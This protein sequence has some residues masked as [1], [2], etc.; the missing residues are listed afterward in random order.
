MDHWHW[1]GR[2]HRS[3]HPGVNIGQSWARGS[4][5]NQSGVRNI[6]ETKPVRLHTDGFSITK[7]LLRRSRGNCTQGMQI[8]TCAVIMECS[9]VPGIGTR[10]PNLVKVHILLSA[11]NDSLFRIIGRVKYW[12]KRAFASDEWHGHAGSCYPRD[13]HAWDKNAPVK[14]ISV[15]MTRI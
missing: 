14:C 10:G 13:G 11:N 3:H 4:A 15:F 8:D 6:Y 9:T 1:Q 2:G 5:T 12:V 7:R